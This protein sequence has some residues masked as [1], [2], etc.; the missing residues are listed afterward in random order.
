MF[1]EISSILA[2]SSSLYKSSFWDALYTKR[3]LVYFIISHNKLLISFPSFKT[4]STFFNVLST[5]YLNKLSIILWTYVILGIPTKSLI[6]SS[7]ILFSPSWIHLSKIESASLIAPSA[8]TAIIFIASFVISIP[9]CSHTIF[10]L[11]II[12]SFDILLKSNLWH[13][14]KIVAGNFCGSVVA[15]INLTCSGGSSNVFNNALKA[16]VDNIWTSSIIYTLYFAFV[17]KKFTS[18]RILL[19]SSTLL[20]D[21]ASISTISVNEPFI[22]PLQISHSLQGSP[23]WGFKQ[24]I[25]LAKILAADVF[26]VPLPPLNK[27]ACPTLPATIW[28]LKVLVICSWPT[29]SEKVIGLNFL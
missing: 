15:K 2:I 26:P 25:A 16:P 11:F 29:I 4:I 23:S 21:A 8:R 1:L 18:S 27:Y 14:D 3:S 22:A 9:L 20:L 19:I 7:S 13:L 10:S 28:F 17:G 6:L 12:F 5:S 24:F